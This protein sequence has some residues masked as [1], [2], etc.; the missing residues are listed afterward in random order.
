M[1]SF[2]MSARD[3][4]IA[5]RAGSLSRYEATNRTAPVSR[6][7]PATPARS[8][9]RDTHVEN[10][11]NCPG[12]SHRL[13]RIVVSTAAAPPRSFPAET[14]TMSARNPLQSDPSPLSCI[15]RAPISRPRRA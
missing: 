14:V 9:C 12:P 13:S 2:S 5:A 8:S 1:A 4:V 7:S 11:P 6:A 15:D 10:R 3:S